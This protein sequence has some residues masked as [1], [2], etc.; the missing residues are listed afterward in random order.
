M[1]N[2]KGTVSKLKPLVPVGIKRSI[3][4]VIPRRYH[5]VFDPDWHRRTIGNLPRWEMLGDLQFE[6]LKERGL[7]PHHFLLDVGCGPLR[8]GV[9]FI[10]YLEPGRYY[11]VEKDEAVLEEARRVELPRHG[12]EHKDPTLVAMA[13]FD[14]RRLGQ[15]FDY[16]IAQ[17]VFTHLPLNNIIRC[18]VRMEDALHEGG[19]FYATIWENPE[20]KR[21]LEDIRQSDHK[22]THF[23]SDSFHYDFATFEWIADGTGLSVEHLGRWGH[24]QN[25]VMLLFTKHAEN[26]GS[27]PEA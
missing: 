4:R 5:R 17:S 8:G 22:V 20:G 16:A 7:E 1:A 23:D 21:N 2:A 25:Q 10:D 14:F 11:G 24:P 9:R 6:Y 15:T 12:L 13:D 26:T 18:L 19:R 27:R 3:K